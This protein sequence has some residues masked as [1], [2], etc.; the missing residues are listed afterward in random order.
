MGPT[1]A[2]GSSP[3]PLSYPRPPLG[4]R[5]GLPPG[6]AAPVDPLRHSFARRRPPSRRMTRHPPPGPE[7]A[8]GPQPPRTAEIVAE[9]RDLIRPGARGCPHCGAAHVQRWGRFSH[10]QRYR[11]SACC[12]TFSDFTA[13]ALRYLKRVDRWVEFCRGVD[14]ATSVRHTAASLGVHRD[15]AFR[16]RHRLLRALL[17][18]EDFRLRGRVAITMF[19]LPFSEKGARQLQRPPRRRKSFWWFGE[20]RAWVLLAYDTAGRSFG[21]CTG[22]GP[23][24]PLDAMDDLA[25]RMGPGAVVLLQRP[26]R[27]AAFEAA[28]RAGV[29]TREVSRGVTSSGTSSSGLAAVSD[30]AGGGVTRCAFSLRRW[31]R[32]F[33]GVATRYLDHYLCWH[34]LCERLTQVGETG[35]DTGSGRDLVLLGRFV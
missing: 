12:R 6:L 14:R 7:R 2:S 27:W 1:A 3:L 34:R 23:P 21:R 9:L 25:G 33:R 31:L 26:F 10:R 18:S 15:T 19:D 16:W 4:L 17:A 32:R 22:V 29:P 35:P 20:R 11:C 5:R 28:R 30:A 13:T 24:L 8:F